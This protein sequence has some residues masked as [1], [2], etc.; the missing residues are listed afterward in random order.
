MN[1]L[2]MINQTR[3]LTIH[4]SFYNPYT[5]DGA[6]YIPRLLGPPGAFISITVSDTTAQRVIYQSTK[7]KIALKL[8]PS[9]AES[10]YALEPGYTYGIMFVV[11]R[12]HLSPGNYR[13]DLKYSNV[14]FY[15]FPEHPVG[16]IT[17]QTTLPLHID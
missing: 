11:E 1:F 2:V 6:V 3:P 12:L 8:N 10:Y 16:E 13:L 14:P 4:F 7:P 17:Y 15:G 9:K 5:S